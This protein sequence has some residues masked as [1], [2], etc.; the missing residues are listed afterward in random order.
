[1]SL[2]A[3]PTPQRRKTIST[4]D[5]LQR[6]LEFGLLLPLR[7][8]L[9]LRLATLVLFSLLAHRKHISRSEIVDAVKRKRLPFAMFLTTTLKSS[10]STDSTFDHA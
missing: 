3:H 10:V 7:A 8:T 6:P 2:S 5:D 4:I 9:R 1:M